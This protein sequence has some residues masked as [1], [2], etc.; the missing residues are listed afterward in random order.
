[1]KLHKWGDIKRSVK[2]SVRSQR[3]QS[4]VSTEVLDLN[5]AELRK[6]LGVTQAQ[7]AEVAKMTQGEVSQLERREDYKLSTLRRYVQALG[8]DVE[9]VAVVGD[10]R[11]TLHGV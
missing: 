11:V 7:L 10:K 6:G 3:V 5:L 2:E 1:M 8:G 4:R 9:I